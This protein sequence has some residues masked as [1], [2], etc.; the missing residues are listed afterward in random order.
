MT[1]PHAGKCPAASVERL[2]PASPRVARCPRG[3]SVAT[4]A[5][6]STLPP[7]S[8]VPL[9]ALHPLHPAAPE[10]SDR[11]HTWASVIRNCL[12]ILAHTGSEA[13]GGSASLSES[14]SEAGWR[15][16]F[17]LSALSQAPASV[18]LCLSAL[19]PAGANGK[20]SDLPFI[21]KSPAYTDHPRPWKAHR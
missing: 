16:N 3:G 13:Q 15:E 2:P 21:T 8:A 6:E 1:A 11:T 5:A 20:D 4:R 19:Q 12:R 7:P 9:C 18:P 10:G 17:G 14:Q